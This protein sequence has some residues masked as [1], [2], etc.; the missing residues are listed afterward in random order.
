MN[1][2][3]ELMNKKE[4]LHEDLQPYVNFEQGLGSL[5][6][7]HP[8]VFQIFLSISNS[9]IFDDV[10]SGSRTPTL[11]ILPSDNQPISYGF[12]PHPLVFPLSPTRE[13]GGDKTKNMNADRFF[14]RVVIFGVPPPPPCFSLFRY[15]GGG[16]CV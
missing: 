12:I 15:H 1:N 10:F 14:S 2:I 4:E 7:K 13:G 8:L 6:L 5:S 16:G 3:N 11:I 9:F